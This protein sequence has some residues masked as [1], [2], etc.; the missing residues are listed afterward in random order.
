MTVIHGRV[1]PCVCVGG[2]GRPAVAVGRRGSS[3][4]GVH[5][6]GCVGVS[7]CGGSGRGALVSGMK[8]LHSGVQT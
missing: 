6:R 3:S 2:R 5:L 7:V 4:F 1:W 8:S